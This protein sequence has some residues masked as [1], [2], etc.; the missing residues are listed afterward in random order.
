MSNLDCRAPNIKVAKPDGL[1]PSL[2]FQAYSGA[3]PVAYAQLSARSEKTRQSDRRRSRSTGSAAPGVS[4]C[5][6]LIEVSQHY[7]NQGIGSALLDEVIKFCKEERVSSIYGEAKGEM[8]FLRKWYQ[9]K[10]F[11]LD[12]AD[13][14]EL[15]INR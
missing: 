14:I 13:N 11:D 4:Y 5:L 1:A 10:G 8:E 12:S 15:H 7:R 6:K 9:G 2:F 3:N